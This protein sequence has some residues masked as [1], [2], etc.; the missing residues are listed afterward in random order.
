M[1]KEIFIYPETSIKEALKKL[2]KTAEKILLVVDEEKRLVG[3]LT[4]G[5]IR[6]Y[7]IKTGKLSGM[8]KDIYNKNPIAMQESSLSE[9][10]I[11]KVFIEKK[12]EVLP[13][14][15]ENNKVVDYLTWTRVFS[16]KEKTRLYKGKEINVPVVI[17][18]GGKGTRLSPFTKVL[19][20][21]LIPVGEKTIIEHII[22]R[23][24]RFGVRKFYITL[25][26]KGE[27]I[28]AYFKG[29]EKDYEVEFIWEETFLGTAGSLKLLED[30]LEKDVFFV[31]NCDILVDADYSEILDFHRNSGSVFTSVTA[32]RHY[33]IPYG[34]V[35]TS[36]GGVIDKIMEKPEYT[37]QINTG[38]YLSN[39]NVLELI[40]QGSPFDM[41]ELINTLLERGEKVFAYPVNEGAYIDIGEW[42]EYKMALK[43]LSL[44]E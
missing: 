40:P 41:P 12:I 18:A 8:V 19:P 36:N 30:K 9:K 7:I 26:Y 15:D 43:K 4:D 32:I 38:V 37:F 10:E 1:K 31:S 35:M 28:E 44:E 23:F 3:T 13:I 34:V 27:M 17:M 22:D 42:K 14:V 6:R 25:N 24:Y 11:K 39:K 16:E 21:P 5:D 20:K 29:L 33:R 2:D